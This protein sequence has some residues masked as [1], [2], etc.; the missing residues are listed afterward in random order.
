MLA[1]ARFVW[2]MHRLGSPNARLDGA[3]LDEDHAQHALGFS[4]WSYSTFCVGPRRTFQWLS[5]GLV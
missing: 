3:V 2:E 4:L 1:S 5:E